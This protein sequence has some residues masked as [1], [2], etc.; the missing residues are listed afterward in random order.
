M[1][2]L[3]GLLIGCGDPAPATDAAAGPMDA[4]A[5]DAG[6]PADAGAPDAGGECTAIEVQAFRLDIDDDT[7]LRVRARITPDVEDAPWDLYL[8][9]QRFAGAEFTGEI[10]LGVAPNES[11]P[12]CP[13][14]VVAFT[15]SD[16]D[17][18][19]LASE[20]TLRLNRSP[21]DGRL[22]V[23]LEGVVLREMVVEA[24]DDPIPY[25]VSRF[26]EDG[27]CLT[28]SSL[29]AEEPLP[30]AGWRCDPELWADGEGCDCA[31]GAWDPD[32]DPCDSFLDPSCDPTAT[33]PTRRCDAADVCLWDDGEG[34]CTT[35]CDTQPCAA[36]F[37]AW[38]PTGDR[39]CVT[40]P[41][42]RSPVGVGGVCPSGG[43]LRYCAIDEGVAGG[44]CAEWI[45]TG[46]DG[47]E[48]LF[49]CWAACARD[50]D[51]GEGLTCQGFGGF[52]GGDGPGY[53]QPPHPRDWTCDPDA[54]GDA[55][56]DCRCGTWDPAC[57][58]ATIYA[59]VG[60]TRCA[61]GE[62]C[63]R[64]DLFLFGS[65]GECVAAPVNDTCA[66]A[67]ALPLDED[68]RAT[69][70][71]ATPSYAAAGCFDA[72][73]S[74]ADLVYA[75]DLMA[76]DG[77]EVTVT[78]DAENPALYLLGPGVSCDGAFTCAAAVDDGGRGAPETL[79]YTATTTGT[80]HLV[81][82][83]NPFEYAFT[84]RASVTR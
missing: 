38:W 74:G 7:G 14:C 10:P 36:G 11:F 56:C 20:G 67:T 61:A 6:D 44:V 25:L 57:G 52:V 64:E 43:G 48:A 24:S 71:G 51:C 49:E 37:C 29:A 80:H 46:D 55:A 13:H 8:W 59:P 79:R 69:T 5:A 19:Y 58:D 68:V 26:V 3:C 32:C 81:V 62:V 63:V 33:L 40:D 34:V 1:L 18:G 72:E 4:G 12:D 73:V 16:L 83:S 35:T 78:P 77:L 50:A 27:A 53:C 23:Q 70:R 41:D 30:A 42:R 76:G 54:W 66:T 75:I 65:E 21:F 60:S 45:A 47:G 28:L 84:L 17:R 2:L 22:D 82:D 15:G 9:F 39:V 31:C